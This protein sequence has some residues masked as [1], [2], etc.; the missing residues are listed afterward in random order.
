LADTGQTLEEIQK[1]ARLL[2]GNDKMFKTLSRQYLNAPP[3]PLSAV[4]DD[5]NPSDFLDMNLN[6]VQRPSSVKD[7]RIGGLTLL[8]PF[9]VRPS[10]AVDVSG[11]HTR[12]RLDYWLVFYNTVPPELTVTFSLTVDQS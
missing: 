8:R 4:S 5:E 11:N 1:L 6:H 12:T 3:S 7:T 2:I 9:S 10:M